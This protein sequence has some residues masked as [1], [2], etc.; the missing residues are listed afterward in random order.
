MLS[1]LVI[2]TGVTA[3]G[4]ASADTPPSG[5]GY[6]TEYSPGG[7]YAYWRNCT[8]YKIKISVDVVWMDDSTRCTPPKSV[9]LL[10]QSGTGI[11]DIRGAKSIG[12]C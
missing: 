1:A 6:F 7:P 5:C 3:T 4:T 9:T 11:G 2:G 8:I 12:R 10:G